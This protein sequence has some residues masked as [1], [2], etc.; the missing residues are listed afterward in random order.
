MTF[1]NEQSPYCTVSWPSY[2]ADHS[3][4]HGYF[5]S[6]LTTGVEVILNS[7]SYKVQC[8]NKRNVH[9]HKPLQ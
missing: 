8:T 7:I 2:N 6:S 3:D 4:P 1:N 9:T 5:K